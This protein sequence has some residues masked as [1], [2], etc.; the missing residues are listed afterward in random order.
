MLIQ[1]TF[2]DYYDGVASS[3]IDTTVHYHRET[4]T[5][6]AESPFYID[7]LPTNL[8]GRPFEMP[9]G[10]DRQRREAFEASLNALSCNFSIIGYCGTYI[11]AA[12]IS[13]AYYFGDSILD[14]DWSNQ[15]RHR[16]SS[17]RQVVVDLISKF[18]ESNDNRL[19]QQF[20]APVF[21]TPMSAYTSDFYQGTFTLN[22]NLKELQFFK[23]KDSYSAFQEIQG[24]ISGVLGVDAKPTIELS[25]KSKIIK[26]GFDPKT[27]F[28]KGKEPPK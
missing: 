7:H 15:K 2:S 26:A 17:V 23:Y 27:S 24:Y 5:I 12:Y 10:T 21:I 28:R 19:F 16:R 18:H 9:S 11:V 25:D 8:F 3:G 13:K 1:S 22:P 14:F 6:S 20:Q 4:H